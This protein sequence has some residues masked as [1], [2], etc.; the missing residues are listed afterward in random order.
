[1]VGA[2]PIVVRK[3]RG[4]G[5]ELR[6][7]LGCCGCGSYAARMDEWGPDLCLERIDTIIGWMREESEKRKVPVSEAAARRM[8]MLAIE[9]A[10][11]HEASTTEIA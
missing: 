7:I 8:I 10:K 1:M 4:P 3:Q 11:Q 6:K 9:R 5:T 2:S